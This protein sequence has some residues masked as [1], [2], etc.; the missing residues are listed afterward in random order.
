M[1]ETQKIM[2]KVDRRDL[3]ETSQEDN[4]QDILREILLGL[5]FAY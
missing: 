1:R 2:Q 3:L 4:K 5:R